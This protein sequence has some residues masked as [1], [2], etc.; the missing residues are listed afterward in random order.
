MNVLKISGNLKEAASNI[1]ANFESAPIL[2]RV[3]VALGHR[4][5]R[6]ANAYKARGTVLGLVWNTVVT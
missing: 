2:P 4:K 3:G 6:C 1:E 5:G